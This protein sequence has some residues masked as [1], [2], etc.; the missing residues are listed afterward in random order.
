MKIK[1]KIIL[2]IGTI[3]ILMGTLSALGFIEISTNI[4]T[5]PPKKGS[6][7]PTKYNK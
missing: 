7:L 6:D 3:I 2:L 1:S 4:T 5:V